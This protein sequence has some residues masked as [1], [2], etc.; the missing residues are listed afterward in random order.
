MHSGHELS[1][2]A[3]CFTFFVQHSVL[4]EQ[5]SL[6][7]ESTDWTYLVSSN[8]SSEL[9]LCRGHAPYKQILSDRLRHGTQSSY[10][11]QWKI[12]EGLT[13][14]TWR[15]PAWSDILQPLVLLQT[16]LW[17]EA[18]GP[19]HGDS[20]PLLKGMCPGLPSI[21][22]SLIFKVWC[23]LTQPEVS[24]VAEASLNSLLMLP[25]PECQG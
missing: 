6:M 1:P 3:L 2:P 23:R 10:A 19:E 21:H 18:L 9:F 20:G 5:Q 17:C 7:T 14:G 4:T 11:A 12:T 24:Y 16:Q 13:A 25:H 8:C 22:L 15:S